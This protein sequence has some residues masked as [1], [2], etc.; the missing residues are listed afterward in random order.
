M[1]SAPEH[2]DS[3][4]AGADS[5]D[6]TIELS[7]RAAPSPPLVRP[8]ILEWI[9]QPLAAPA[10]YLHFRA[11]Q[12]ILDHAVPATQHEVGGLLVGALGDDGGRFAVVTDC[13]PA[14]RARESR[15]NLTFTHESWQQLYADQARLC[16]GSAILG[17]YHTHPGYGVFL[18]QYDE[19]IQR[20]FFNAPHL[21]ALVYDPVWRQVG[22]FRWGAGRRERLTGFPVIGDPD[23]AVTVA[24]RFE[25][26]HPGAAAG[27][28]AVD[29]RSSPLAAETIRIISRLTEMGEQVDRV[30]RQGSRL[31]E[32]ELR[33]AGGSLEPVIHVLTEPDVFRG[34]EM[35]PEA[36]PPAASGGTP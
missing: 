21:Y 16:P 12:H 32:A 18:S 19:Y 17:W 30:A 24:S 22:L 35:E 5:L 4:V 23:Q 3:P 25:S 26:P 29:E 9:G 1:P 20:S 6:I 27:G 15:A 28:A 8:R 34:P 33:G 7:D 10:V 36:G 2:G 14:T 11:L 13:L 31:I